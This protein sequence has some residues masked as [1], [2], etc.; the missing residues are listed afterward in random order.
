[1]LLAGSHGRLLLRR[2]QRFYLL[3]FPLMDFADAL[4]LLLD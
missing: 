3:P 1:L 2:Y 4:P